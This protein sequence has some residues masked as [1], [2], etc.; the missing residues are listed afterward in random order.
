MA[1]SLTSSQRE[2][3]LAATRLWGLTLLVGIF[4]LVLGF[5]I[6]GYDD[7]SLTAL[8]IFMGVSFL[9]T[10]LTW[11]VFAAVVDE[12]KWFWVIGALL[13]LGGGIVAFVYPDETLKILSLILGWF[14]LLTGIVQFIAALTNRDREGWWLNLL[15]GVVMFGLGAWAVGETDRSLTLLTTLV[16]V[17]C[18]LKGILDILIALRQRRLKRELL[19]SATV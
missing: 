3:A 18:V 17:Y 7:R 14:L 9:M 5:I 8:S 19:E 4:F 2:A 15:V 10:S 1:A 6:L 13:A 11:F 12:L 16:G